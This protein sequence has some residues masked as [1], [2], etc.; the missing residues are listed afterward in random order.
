MKTILRQSFT[1]LA[2]QGVNQVESPLW[3]NGLAMDTSSLNTALL[4]EWTQ[5]A[6][7]SHTGSYT[8]D[9]LELEFC[10]LYIRNNSTCFSYFET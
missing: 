4:S 9:L 7:D 5:V 3:K 10:Y 6:S 8:A 1:K 2:G